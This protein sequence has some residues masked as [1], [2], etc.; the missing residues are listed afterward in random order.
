MSAIVKTRQLPLSGKTIV[1]TRSKEQAKEFS[2]LLEQYGAR[3]LLFPAV[4]IVDPQ[5][6][7]DCDK[8]LAKPAEYSGI[9]FTSVNAVQYFFR[10]AKKLKVM[11]QLKKCRVF[12]VGEKT[13]NAIDMYGMQSEKLSEIFSADQLANEIVKSSEVGE[14]FLF[15]KGNLAKNDI[16]SI[17]SSHGIIVD[18]ITVYCTQEPPFDDSRKRILKKIEENSDLVTFFSPSSVNNFVT[19]ASSESITRIPVAVIGETTAEV[20]RHE[21]MNVVLVASQ[22]TAGVFADSILHYYAK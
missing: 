22:S 2:L 15:P 12:A 17:L 11:E 3:V 6:W 14:R 16:Q 5:S 4:E 21:G 19:K 20:A 7:S 8:A 18:A 13:K 9:I 1:V 10:R